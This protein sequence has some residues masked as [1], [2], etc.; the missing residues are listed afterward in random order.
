MRSVPGGGAEEWSLPS[1]DRLAQRGE[2]LCLQSCRVS[3]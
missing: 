3:M 2:L 1:D